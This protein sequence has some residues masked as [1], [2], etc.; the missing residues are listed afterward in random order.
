MNADT[1]TA[2]VQTSHVVAIAGASGVVGSLVLPQLLARKD[3]AQVVAVGRRELRPALEPAQL[4][5]LQTRVAELGHAAE[6]AAVLPALTVAVC[7]L[8]T[9][10]KQAGSNA[11]FRA[12]DFDA[13]LAFAT[14]SRQR[15]AQHFVLVSALGADPRSRVYYSRTKGEAESAI[16]Q[17]D[18]PRVTVLRPSLIDDEGLRSEVRLGERLALPLSRAV[19]G[20]VGRT[21]RY[22]PVTAKDLAASLVRLAFDSDTERFRV[23]ES[24]RLHSP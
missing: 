19:F 16:G 12:V 10:R 22:A 6:I 24:E 21:H 8:G 2:N 17:L 9:T 3:V 15:G 23:V 14:A 1:Q 7:C 20:I 5:K 4:Q 11:A 13:V 18:F